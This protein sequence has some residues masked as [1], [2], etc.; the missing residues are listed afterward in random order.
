MQ[1]W[2]LIS[3]RQADIWCLTHRH[4]PGRLSS[5]YTCLF[6]SLHSQTYCMRRGASLVRHGVVEFCLYL[7]EHH[8]ATCTYACIYFFFAS[9]SSRVWPC[10]SSSST[11]ALCVCTHPPPARARAAGSGCWAA[12]KGDRRIACLVVDAVVASGRTVK[13][14]WLAGFDYSPLSI[15]SADEPAAAGKKKRNC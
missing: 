14:P 9:S 3:E 5:I 12:G 2:I 4:R 1:E 10:A 8:A 6:F 13:E 7:K 15:A 11:H